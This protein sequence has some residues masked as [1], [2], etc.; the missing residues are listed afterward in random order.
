[1]STLIFALLVFLVLYAIALAI[2][3]VG[4]WWL[5]RSRGER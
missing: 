4:E 5:R 1:M 2:A 3:Y